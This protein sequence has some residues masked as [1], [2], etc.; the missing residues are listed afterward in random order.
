MLNKVPGGWGWGKG[1]K[2]TMGGGGGGGGVKKLT[3]GRTG[4]LHRYEWVLT[5][6][7]GKKDTLMK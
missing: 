2:Q 6:R 7:D 1:K 5:Q 3:G 4:L